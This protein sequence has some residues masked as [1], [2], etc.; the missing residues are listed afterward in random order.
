MRSSVVAILILLLGGSFARSVAASDVSSEIGDGAIPSPNQISV[1][2]RTALGKFNVMPVQPI[3]ESSQRDR[4][5]LERCAW[6]YDGPSP[7]SHFRRAIVIER[8]TDFTI[9]LLDSAGVAAD[10]LIYV[11]V[12]P[13][14]YGLLFGT[15]DEVES[16]RIRS[17]EL[18]VGEWR[19]IH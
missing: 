9:F 18:I 1:W 14:W 19:E 7:Y 12:E 10:S 17:D 15:T 3:R 6:I 13:G 8:K 16:I 2:Y 11:G 5:D 4:A